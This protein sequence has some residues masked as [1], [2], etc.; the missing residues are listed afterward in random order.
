MTKPATTPGSRVRPTRSPVPSLLAVALVA[1]ACDDTTEPP[2]PNGAPRLADPIPAQVVHVGDT[3]IVDVTG[4]FHEPD[5]DALSYAATSSNTEVVIAGA[6]AGNVH[7]IG[8]GQGSATVTVTATDPEGFSATQS[9]DVSVPNRA[10]AVTDSIPLLEVTGDSV[11]VD[12]LEFLSDPDGDALSFTAETSDSGVVTAMVSESILTLT[13]TAPGRADITVTASD[14]SGLTLS[15]VFPA[16]VPNLPP[17]VTRRIP[18]LDLAGDSVSIDLSRF[19]DDPNG[20]VLF[21]GAE[22]SDSGVATTVATDHFVALA[23]VGRGTADITVTVTDPNGL[24]ASQVFRARVPNR[25]PVVIDTLPT[26]PLVTGATAAIDL[27]AHLRDPEGRT[28]RHVA[29]SSDPEVATTTVS[30]GTLNIAAVSTG[31]ATVTVTAFDPEDLSISV[32]FRATVPDD[33]DR[34]A[35]VA[36]Y[37][38]TGGPY[39]RRSTNWLTDAPLEQWYGVEVDSGRVVGLNLRNNR[40]RNRV[41]PELVLLEG[42]RELRLDWNS[43][44]GPVPAELGRLP[45]LRHLELGNNDLTGPVP[46]EIGRLASLEHL[47]LGDN[48]LTGSVTRAIAKLSNLQSL[49]LHRNRLTGP[50]PGFL[51]E[52]GSLNRLELYF[53][54]LTGPIPPTIAELK[55]L[56]TLDLGGNRLTGA[57]P[58]EMGQLANLKA[59]MLHS[60]DLTGPIPPGLG[61]LLNL[62][63]LDLQTN[64]L[65]GPIPPELGD[66]ASLQRLNLAANELEGPVPREL[67]RMASLQY[68][69]LNNNRLTGPL[70]RS[71]LELEQL[72]IFTAEA[73]SGL[74]VPGT[75]AF[76]VLLESTRVDGAPYC[77]QADLVALAQL[78]DAT[79]GVDWSR[80]GGWLD[81]AALDRWLGVTTD[82]LGHVEEL[83]LHGNGLSGR[84]PATLGQALHRMVRLRIGDNSL[85]GP[86]PM[87]LAGVPLEEL[88]Y[89]STD[90]CFP[91]DE[92]FQDWLNA[93]AD[94]QGTGV[95]CPPLS[96]YEILMTFYRATDGPEWRRNH[97]WGTGHPF[98]LWQGVS[99]V[100]DGI[101][102]NL[103]N[104]GLTGRIPPELGLLETL[105]GLDLSF[106][107]LTGSIPSE[108]GQLARLKE[109]D[110]SGNGLTGPVP[111]Q[112]GA[113]SE[114]EELVLRSNHLTDSVPAA[115]GAL[116]ALKELD[117]SGNGLGGRIPP[118]LGDLSGLEVLRLDHN[119]LNGPIPRELGNL[120]RLKSLELERNAITGQIPPSLGDLAELEQLSLEKNRLT[121]PLPLE[122]GNLAN[123]RVL[124]AYENRLTGSIPPHLGNLAKLQTLSLGSN[125]LTGSIPPRLGRLADLKHLH[126]GENRLTGRLPPELGEITGLERLVLRDNNLAG[127]IPSEM[128]NLAE[129]RLLSLEDNGLTGRVPGELGSLAGLEELYLARNAG[130]FGPLPRHWTNLQRLDALRAGTTGLCA[131]PGDEFLDWL[132]G[133]RNRRIA[134]CASEA[135]YLTQAVQSADFPVTLI[136]GEEALLRV[137]VTATRTTDAHIPAMRATFLIEGR[138]VYTADIPSQPHP[139]PT[140]VDESRMSKSANAHIPGWVVQP[141]LGLVIEVDPEDSLDP[142]LGVRKRIPETGQLT[143]EVAAVPPLELTLVPF[144]WSEKPDSAIVDLVKAMA[145]DPTDHELLR[146]TR[147]LLPVADLDVTA[148]EPVLSSHNN[149]LDLYR[150]T[151]MIRIL[152]RGSKVTGPVHYMGMM[153]GAL[154]NRIVGVARRPGR[155]SFSTPNSSVMAHELGHNMSLRHAPCGGVWSST[156]D[157]DYPHR[158]GNIGAWGYDF[159]DGGRLVDVETPDV[160][161]YCRPRWISDYFFSEALRYRLEDQ[162]A[163]GAVTP[164]TRSLLLWGGTDVDGRPILEP[165]FV[166]E[167]RPL[168]PHAGGDYRL[169]GATSDGDQLFSLDF[170]MPEITDGDGAGAFTFALPVEPGW[171]ATLTRITLAGPAGTVTLDRGSRASAA[172]LIDRRS[173]QVRAILRGI[174]TVR[175]YAGHQLGSLQGLELL[176]SHGVPDGPAWRR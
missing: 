30:A 21:F 117:L 80:S 135:A 87:S 154:A 76:V 37:E 7:L 12:L 96:D 169:T 70:P 35:L 91:A 114:L 88:R 48:Q 16:N 23:A 168:L 142:S 121:G 8:I 40:L 4:H 11:S 19:F 20:T 27:T 141:G 103:H 81:G 25:A 45:L 132:K 100:G 102:L 72:D 122:L 66:L 36:L 14:P 119:Q 3:A 129:L 47:N 165:A 157:P 138:E 104:N 92:S 118:A 99:M 32:S 13:A 38:A 175:A 2:T 59:L 17:V 73:N 144:L 140:A 85:T 24:S 49:S 173:G 151:E 84:L 126:L 34:A 93:I 101:W 9:F 127:P 171:A 105:E 124:S 123:L 107:S 131:P 164:S 22:T 41:P 125:G 60:N 58:P 153:S 86:L 97:N 44:S 29:E 109:L 174:A 68:V 172:I 39:W 146:D 6:E 134:R 113:L 166:A 53:N 26:L 133:M 160:M 83:D 150:E 33:P 18:D 147:T 130:L 170:E 136:A 77:N 143:P 28:L 108:L 1:A 110:V 51:A 75:Q 106:N 158:G 161:S 176:L 15:A 78:Y 115:L 148:H 55:G 63:R 152:E 62:R 94:H 149:A 120:A 31:V 159:T 145:Q 79:G 112:L 10:P 167:A 43:L 137:F 42:L 116:T 54:R 5:G 46:P 163:A 56:E 74:C 65:T 69:W 95:E 50:I 98:H 57:I 156:V 139:I 128:G 64:N 162:A 155:V 61:K 90:L 52:L 82:S 89:G 111:A 71:L 67:G